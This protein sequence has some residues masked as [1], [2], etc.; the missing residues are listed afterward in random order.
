MANT[1]TKK[2]KHDSRLYLRRIQY[3][4]INTTRGLSFLLHSNHH[5]NHRAKEPVPTAFLVSSGVVFACFKVCIVFW[6]AFNSD[7]C[8]LLSVCHS[9]CCFCNEETVVWVGDNSLGVEVE[10]KRFFKCWSCNSS[11]LLCFSF[12]LTSC[13]NSFV[14]FIFLGRLLLCATDLPCAVLQYLIS[15]RI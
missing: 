9:S 4:R 11:C 3:I 13:F 8:C 10:H 6:M 15:Q 14:L 1:S 12:A 5:A 2:Q 7:I